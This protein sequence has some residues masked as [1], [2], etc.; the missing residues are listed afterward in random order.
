MHRIIKSIRRFLPTTIK[1]L[2]PTLFFATILIFY[3]YWKANFEFLG[4]N[5]DALSALS[6]IVTILGILAALGLSYVRFFAGRLF[7][8]RTQVSIEI[9][10]GNISANVNIHLVR[11]K[12]HNPGL[13]SLYVDEV[14][15]NGTNYD[16]KGAATTHSTTD[17]PGIRD[18][19]TDERELRVDPGLTSIFHIIFEIPKQVKVSFYEAVVT[20]STGGAWVD[21]ALVQNA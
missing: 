1:I 14:R 13:L 12:V 19:L 10:T 18:H 16:A 15:I 8:R 6:S 4:A 3:L 20:D 21:T 9:S 5:K 11:I 7:S 17:F 2:A